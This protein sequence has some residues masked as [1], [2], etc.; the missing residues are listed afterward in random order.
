MLG[1]GTGGPLLRGACQGERTTRS[2]TTGEPTSRKRPKCPSS[3]PP[4]R[5][6][7][8]SSRGSSSTN[9]RRSS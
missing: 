5:P 6:G 2:R 1:G 8:A 4:R 3:T 9:S 7:T